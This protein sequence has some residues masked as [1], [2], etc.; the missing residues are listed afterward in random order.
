MGLLNHAHRFLKLFL[1]FALCEYED[2]D[3]DWRIGS[4]ESDSVVEFTYGTE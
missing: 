1:R 4:L 3:F 2:Y